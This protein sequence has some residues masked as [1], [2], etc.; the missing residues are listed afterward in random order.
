[1]KAAL[2][3]P[4][5]SNF[6]HGMDTILHFLFWAVIE[7]IFFRFGRFVLST[8]SLGVIRL[9]KPTPFQ[10][11]A[12]AGFG[13]LVLIGVIFAMDWAVTGNATVSA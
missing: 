9:E 2:A 1:M 11:F 7:T 6:R 10:V 12:V 13:F 3:Q 4:V 8:L 5:S